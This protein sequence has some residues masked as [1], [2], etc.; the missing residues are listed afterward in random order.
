MRN[1]LRHL[2]RAQV[3]R[4]LV[5]LAFLIATPAVAQ[6]GGSTPGR[7]F[8]L[9][10]GLGTG[11]QQVACE[12]CRAD[13]NGGWAA[14]F[15]FGHRIRPGLDLGGEIHGWVDRTDDIQFRSLAILPAVYWRPG[16]RAKYHLIG[17]IGYTTY[18]AG[19]DDE[20]ISSSGLGFT[21][22]AGLDLSVAGRLF[23]TPFA[24]FT[25]SFLANLKHERTDITRAQ[26]SL[27]QLGIGFTRR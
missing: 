2:P 6:R 5:L 26:L 19:N 12:I 24:T 3:P 20:T 16:R 22:G 9:S 13:R 21:A 11:S 18:R 8:W 25:A 14:R 17:G 15:A 7:G 10:A 4:A 27:L 23:L 1:P